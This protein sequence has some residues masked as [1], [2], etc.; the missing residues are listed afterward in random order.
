MVVAH[1]YQIFG[2]FPFEY[3]FENKNLAAHCTVCCFVRNG[4]TGRQNSLALTIWGFWKSH[5]KYDQDKDLKQELKTAA[6][7]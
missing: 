4:Q 5:Q 7:S 1:S 3:A 6:Q 2:H